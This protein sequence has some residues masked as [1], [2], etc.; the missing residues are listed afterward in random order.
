MIIVIICFLV[1]IIL[2]Q[3]YNTQKRKN[4]EK[5]IE[6]L[7]QLI[8]EEQ[9]QYNEKVEM[10]KSLKYVNHD[11]QKYMN[12]VR[13]VVNNNEGKISGDDIVNS[14]ICQKKTESFNLGVR[15]TCEKDTAISWRLTNSEIIRI[16]VNLLENAIEAAKK[17]KKEPFVFISFHVSEN[18]QKVHIII[19]NSKNPGEKPLECGMSTSKENS[20][21][22]GYGTGI[23]RDIVEKYG[24]DIIMEDKGDVFEV[25]VIV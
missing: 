14:I 21:F 2:I 7:Q 17:V 8:A 15:F 20:E 13:E 25:I 11:L 19:N 18:E 10:H 5:E 16:L 3:I 6:C 12:V 24:G 9:K 22:H 1:C 23:I 4:L